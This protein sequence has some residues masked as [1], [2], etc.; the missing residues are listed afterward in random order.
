M[1]F[2][3][4][5]IS[6]LWRIYEKSIEIGKKIS[7]Q[8]ASNESSLCYYNL[9]IPILI[10]LY[11]LVNCNEI[12]NFKSIKSKSYY[13]IFDNLCEII[14]SNNETQKTDSAKILKRITR[15]ILKNGVLVFFPSEKTRKDCFLKM[16][17]NNI[18]TNL[19]KETSVNLDVKTDFSFKRHTTQLLFEAFCNLFCLDKY[20]LV[21][22]LY[23]ALKM[24]DI[25]NMSIGTSS[26]G[27]NLNTILNFKNNSQ[28]GDKIS[29]MI[30]TYNNGKNII[31]NKRGDVD[32]SY[33]SYYSFKDL[34]HSN[35]EDFAIFEYEQ[36]KP[37]LEDFTRIFSE[38]LELTEYVPKDS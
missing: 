15:E 9:R 5:E 36:S 13:N 20:I 11:E 35:S 17:E 23:I 28:N 30:S 1:I 4:F 33:N 31:F 32:N 37:I 29:K 6:D 22:Y 25:E 26:I 10:L 14:D 38:Y 21:K 34:H 12:K 24:R 8:N 7:E 18:D 16:I 3:D 27:V 19:S 2:Q